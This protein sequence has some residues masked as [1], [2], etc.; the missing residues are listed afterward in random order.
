VIL[1][2]GRVPVVQGQGFVV[3]QGTGGGPWRHLMTA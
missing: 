3:T 1:G 2:N